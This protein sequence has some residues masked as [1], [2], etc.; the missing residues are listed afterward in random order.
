VDGTDEGDWAD[1][2]NDDGDIEDKAYAGL[3]PLG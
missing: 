1:E 3:L 2:E